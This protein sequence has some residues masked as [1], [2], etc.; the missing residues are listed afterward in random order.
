MR[1]GLP[2]GFFIG[3]GIPPIRAQN[4]LRRAADF[5]D[6]AAC[7]ADTGGLRVP[8]VCALYEARPLALRP[9]AGFL[10]SLRVHAAVLAIFLASVFA[11]LEVAA[12][13][14]ANLRAGLF[15]PP[16]LPS[17]PIVTYAFR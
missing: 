15:F 12:F 8:P 1:V 9:P 16:S 5:G 14:A 6:L 4:D 2:F 11:R 10:P 7:L 3:P 17:P 13:F